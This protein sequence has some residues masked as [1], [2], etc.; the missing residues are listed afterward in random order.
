[1]VIG[2]VPRDND[3]EEM[4]LGQLSQGMGV[5]SLSKCHGA[6]MVGK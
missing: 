6:M 3:Y 5:S 1:M 4:L 2:Q